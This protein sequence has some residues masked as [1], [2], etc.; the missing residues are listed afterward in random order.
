MRVL[1]EGKEE[2][3]RLLHVDAPEPG[4]WGYERVK[5]FTHTVLEEASVQLVFEVEGIPQWDDE[6]RLLAYIFFEGWNFNEELVYQ[7]LSR[8]H[9]EGGLGRFARDFQRAES[10]ARESTRGFWGV[11]WP[12][13]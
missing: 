12:S 4:D 11:L 2:R 10:L 9:P 8:F 3:V 5:A 1:S 6:G 13:P 7:G